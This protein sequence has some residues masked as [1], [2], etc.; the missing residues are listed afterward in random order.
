MDAVSKLSGLISHETM[1]TLLPFID[2]PALEIEKLKAEKEGS[3]YEDFFTV[4]EEEPITEPA[5]PSEPA[6][7]V[8]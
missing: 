3:M 8:I 4:D 5:E 7:E 6:V 1:L 2:D